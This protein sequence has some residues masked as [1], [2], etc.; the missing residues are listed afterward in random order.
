MVLGESNENSIIILQGLQEGEEVYISVPEEPEKCKFEGLELAEV[1]KA[2]KADE[3][4]KMQEM[5]QTPENNQ[6]FRNPDRR[7]GNSQRGERQR[8]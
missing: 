6:K 2:R 1:I 8:D 4:R 3:E 5:K 7:N